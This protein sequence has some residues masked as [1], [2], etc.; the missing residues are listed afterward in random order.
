MQ[1]LP[2]IDLM[3]GQAVRGRSGDRAS[4]RP[5]LSRL[6]GG[7]PEDLSDPVSLLRACRETWGAVRAY[8]A[9]LDRIAGSG[10]NGPSIERLFENAGYE[11]F[12]DQGTLAVGMPAVAAR[13]GIVPIVAT[14]TLRSLSDLAVP[15]PRPPGGAL[16]G[17]DLGPGGVV[18]RSPEIAALAPAHLLRHAAEAGFSGAI[19][20]FLG[21]VGT[22][23]G[24]PRDRLRSLREAV[25]DLDLWVGGGIARP[26]DLDLLSSLGY[27]GALVAAAL[28][29]GWIRPADLRRRGF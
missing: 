21:Q 25:P 14:E 12:L 22:G 28:H 11:L 13:P 2:V 23:A 27:T 7:E 16:F 6:R 17:L 10:D 26:D 19:V 15:A 29:E 20:L 1:I 3:R 4:Y 18:T 5:V 9:D 8:V 24:L